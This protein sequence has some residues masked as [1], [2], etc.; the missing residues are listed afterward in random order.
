MMGLLTFKA[1]DVRRVVEHSINAPAQS[2]RLVDYDDAGKAI[3]TPVDTPHVLLVHDQ[4]V[5]LMSNGRPRDIVDADA[6]D[7]KDES[8][9]EGRSFVAYATGCDPEIDEDWYDTARALVGGDDF[10][11]WLPWALDLK[12]LIDAGAK[13]ITL[14]FTSDSVEIYRS[15]K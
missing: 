2:E 6:T 7:R 11:E 10:G 12:A 9:N 4:G 14:R 13:T 5:Y 15:V 8:I 3:T 1:D